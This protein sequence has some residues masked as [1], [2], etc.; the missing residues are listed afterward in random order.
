MF[1]AG[2]AGS[3]SRLTI[4]SKQTSAS[5]KNTYKNLYNGVLISIKIWTLIISV[6]LIP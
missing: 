2:P 5:N 1:G 6:V 4:N 3:L